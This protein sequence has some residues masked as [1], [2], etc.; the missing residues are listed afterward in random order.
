MLREGPI[1][2][3]APLR[4]SARE[5]QITCSISGAH[6]AGLMPLARHSR[7]VTPRQP[8]LCELTDCRTTGTYRTAEPTHVKPTGTVAYDEPVV[9][10]AQERQTMMEPQQPPQQVCPSPVPLIRHPPPF[11]LLVLL[12]CGLPY[13]DCR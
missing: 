7:R 10:L 12:G 1:V 3:G 2:D 13:S 4:F 11:A 9:P 5:L 8:E 6:A